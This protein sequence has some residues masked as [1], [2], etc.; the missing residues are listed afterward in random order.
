MVQEVA[1]KRPLQPQQ[2][3]IA[4][5]ATRFLYMLA[6]LSRSRQ[7]YVADFSHFNSRPSG[8]LMERQGGLFNCLATIEDGAPVSSVQALASNMPKNPLQGHCGINSAN[9]SNNMT[10][11]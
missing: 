10:G 7:A 4:R 6:G 9:V 8:C 11:Y 2:A 5:F 3:P 1:D